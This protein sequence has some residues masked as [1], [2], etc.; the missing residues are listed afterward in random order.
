MKVSII[1]VCLNAAPFIDQT[2]TSVLG[3]DYPD[4]EYIIVDGGS[5]D[6]TIDILRKYAGD[7]RLQWC[8]GPDRGISDA[9]NKGANQAAGDIL[10]FINADDY[11]PHP[12]VISRV[13]EC[14]LKNPDS[15]WLTGGFDFVASDG[16]TLR[17]FRVRRYSFRRLVRG[18]ILQH[19]STFVRRDVFQSVGGYDDTLRYCMDYDLFLR[20]GEI[21][22]PYLLDEK[23]SCF[24]VHPDSRTMAESGHSYAEEFLVKSRF[25]RS[26]GKCLFL[27]R[28]DYEVKRHLNRLFYRRLVNS[29]CV[30]CK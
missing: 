17:S 12:G 15:V 10:A 20:F 4:I 30:E 6:G 29:S 14:F 24:R 13:V 11:Y 25:L 23:L 27:P 9:M 2:I 3:Q 18:N 1:T 22:P 8:S 7:K 5:S 26:R 21:A 19:P 16:V 28:L